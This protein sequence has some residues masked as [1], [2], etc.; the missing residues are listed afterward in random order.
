MLTLANFEN[1]CSTNIAHVVFD[2]SGTHVYY[3][4]VCNTGTVNAGRDHE[5]KYWA[6]WTPDGEACPTDYVTEY[7][8][9]NDALSGLEAELESRVVIVG[10]HLKQ[11]EPQTY[12]LR[13]VYGGCHRG[14]E[15]TSALLSFQQAQD[16]DSNENI[17]QIFA[18]K[19]SQCKALGSAP[20]AVK[21]QCGNELKTLAQ[22]L[23]AGPPKPTENALIELQ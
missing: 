6:S 22:K 17:R 7:I 2:S 13:E 19:V 12:P 23:V 11:Q 5:G 20:N 9:L 4:E 10:T 14:L 3:E 8:C 16:T 15:G 1:T 21:E 18:S